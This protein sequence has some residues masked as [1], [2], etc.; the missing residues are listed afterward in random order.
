MY[1]Y[2]N[3]FWECLR[4]FVDGGGGCGGGGNIFTEGDIKADQILQIITFG[5]DKSAWW[6]SISL[7]TA[8][9]VLCMFL[10]KW[11]QGRQIIAN[12]CV[13]LQQDSLISKCKC[14]HYSIGFVHVFNWRRYQG[15]Q[16][17]AK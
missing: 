11:Y 14:L 15:R 9:V 12:H 1:L 2:L 3:F 10:L 16:I 13:W 5:Y 8:V 6:I 4:H 17:V 7:S